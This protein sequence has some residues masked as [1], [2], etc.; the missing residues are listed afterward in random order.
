V[1]GG[2]AASGTTL[3]QRAG[4][5]AAGGW[6]VVVT[7]ESAG[8]GFSGLRVATLAADEALELATGDAE[9]IVL[10]LAG[11]F[12]VSCEDEVIEL[13]GRP[14]PFSGP[15]DFAY[16]PPDAGAT[17][18]SAVGGR[19]AVATARTERR[20]PIRHGS[21][22]AVPVELR[23]AGPASRL[24][25][26]FGTP[27]AFEADRLIAVEVLTPGGNW[28]S[29]PPHKH[30]EAGPTETVLEES[31]YYEVA[32]GPDGTPG[33]GYQRVYGTADRPIDVLVEVRDGDVVLIPHGWHGPSMAAPGYDLYYLNVM[34][35]PG[36]ERA[37]RVAFDPAHDW[38]RDAWREQAI[39]SRIAG[40][41]RPGRLA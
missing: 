5:S 32:A 30:D 31:Y 7:P 21:A 40:L 25:R 28:S 41:A 22:E 15:T 3:H 33:I 27:G 10:P 34:A 2:P 38:V 9:A 39:D 17:I 18:S 24:V 1:A 20:L 6:S 11:G 16:L 35:G 29:F 37:W 13:A 12:R 8:W 23:G 14:D 19:V 26:N 4:S 36:D